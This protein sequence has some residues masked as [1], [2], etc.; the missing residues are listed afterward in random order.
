MCIRDRIEM[1]Y[2]IIRPE[3]DDGDDGDVDVNAPVPTEVKNIISTT[4]GKDTG[5]NKVASKSNV[6]K[7]KIKFVSKL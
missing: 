6:L 1:F 5:D 7:N 2:H 4:E 3:E